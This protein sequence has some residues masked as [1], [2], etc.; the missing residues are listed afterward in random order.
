MLKEH[1]H[2]ISLVT[3]GENFKEEVRTKLDFRFYQAE[4]GENG[5]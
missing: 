3:F 5:V 4:K 1:R 2:R